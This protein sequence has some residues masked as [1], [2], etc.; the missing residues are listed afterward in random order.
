[1][2]R[3][4]FL[5]STL[6]TS[7]ALEVLPD[8]AR[9]RQAAPDASREYYVLRRYHVTSGAQRKLT[10]TYLRDALVPALKRLSIS[11][12]G[13]FSVEIGPTSP[14]LYVLMPGSSVESLVS[15]DLHLVHDEQYM[16][17]GEDFLNVSAK[18][19][20]YVRVES[21]LMIAFEGWPKLTVPPVTAQHGARVFELRTYESPTDQDHR[22]KVEMFH[23]GE[24]DIFQ[25]AGFWQVFY[26]DTLVGANQ[27]NL[28][29]MIGF[30][31]LA[32]RDE[33]WNAF[34]NNEDWKKLT[35]SPRFSFE[36]IVSNVTNSILTPTAYSQI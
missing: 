32:E 25:K 22:R 29:Y 2:N 33:K 8:P 18:D 14:S 19:P 34:R 9:A 30:P 31:T 1:M 17:A 26:G 13:A 21:S 23:S 36:D 11:P 6:A 28:T 10:D 24:F 3:R 16:K 5:T 7:A 4:R 27:P 15:A 20:A 35:K 12:V